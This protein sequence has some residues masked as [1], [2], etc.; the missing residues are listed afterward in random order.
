[1]T[2]HVR[3]GAHP[4]GFFTSGRRDLGDAADDFLPLFFAAGKGKA[5][6]EL[7]YHAQMRRVGS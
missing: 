4:N 5:A 3:L 1:M 6:L 7:A 2:G